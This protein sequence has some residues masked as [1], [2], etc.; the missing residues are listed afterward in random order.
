M[1]KGV[2]ETGATSARDKVLTERLNQQQQLVIFL[3]HAAG[4]AG[5][6]SG[7]VSAGGFEFL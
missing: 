1:G 6:D 4:G 2:T 3:A 5:Y 7:S